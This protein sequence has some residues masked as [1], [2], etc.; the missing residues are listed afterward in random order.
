MSEP[1]TNNGASD[2]DDFSQS[3]PRSKFRLRFSL[4]ALIVFVTVAC[5]ALAWLVQP[6]L[7][8]ATALFE[9]AS[10]RPTL[11]G[12]ESTVRFDEREFELLKN[13]QR[14]KLSSHYVVYKALR[15]PGIAA[16]PI[17]AGK[18]DPAAWLQKRLE[19][20]FPGGGE[21]LA[22]RLRG[23][24]SYANDLAKLVDAVAQAYEEEVIYDQRSRTLQER[25]LRAKL[26]QSLT[27]EVSE[28][29]QRLYDMTAEMG[30]TAKDSVEI[31]MLQQELDILTEQMG[32]LRR[33]LERDDLEANSPP[34]IR[35]V[36]PA[37]VSPE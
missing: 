13:T 5:L 30:E 37:V 22:I 10:V 8:V 31:K 35:K 26:L 20:D 33:R 29:M 17:L 23:P 14:A 4:L 27:E 9:V 24:E 7:V 19:V 3:P 6:N 15:Q 12:D 21:I 32:E 2:L 34:R 1:S 36:Q 16:L 18:S 11:L 25:D 28:S